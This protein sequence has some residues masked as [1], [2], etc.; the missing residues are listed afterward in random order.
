M[1]KAE[2]ARLET[3]LGGGTRKRK[4]KKTRKFT[5][6]EPPEIAQQTRILRVARAADAARDRAGRPSVKQIGSRA[7]LDILK[8]QE[9][10]E[11]KRAQ[12]KKERK[13]TDQAP[14][15]IAQQTRTLK[16]AQAA[17][18]ARD[19]AGRPSV[20]QI[21]SRA[22]LTILEKLE[23]REKKRAQQ[24]KERKFTDQAPP[25][26]AQQ[27][28]TLKAAQAADAARDRAGRPSVKQIGSRATLD[29]LEKQD[30]KAQVKEARKE[31]RAPLRPRS[32]RYDSSTALAG[33]LPHAGWPPSAY[34][35]ASTASRP[36]QNETM[37]LSYRG[38][39]AR[40]T[41]GLRRGQRD[42]PCASLHAHLMPSLDDG[43]LRVQLECSIC[44]EN[45]TS[46][47]EGNKS[48][49]YNSTVA[50]PTATDA[51]SWHRQSGAAPRAT[52]AAAPPNRC[53]CCCI[54]T[55]D[56]ARAVTPT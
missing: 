21:G 13:F 56:L 5:S 31:E 2:I 23:A 12:Q 19:R 4:N 34:P 9:A 20:K 28:R 16:A 27:T 47:K 49:M 39:R 30:R 55:V 45:F 24:K 42:L 33:C 43:V 51:G 7:T 38:V 54:S 32:K 22:T 50:A 52:A 10:R 6:K 46:V 26:I 1:G 14:P 44:H 25:E 36:P 41:T 18:A 3:L 40:R 29:I 53:C 37:A 8:N 17:D 11:K 48:V 15:E 35:A